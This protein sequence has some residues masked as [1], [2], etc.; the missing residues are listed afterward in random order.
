MHIE[1]KQEVWWLQFLMKV[2][3]VY[4]IKHKNDMHVPAALQKLDIVCLVFFSKFRAH[5]LFD[6]NLKG[7]I[8]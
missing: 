2:W 1:V 5:N 7:L 8:I 4:F 6:G 3:D